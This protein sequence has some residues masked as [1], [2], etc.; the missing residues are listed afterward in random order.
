MKEMGQFELLG[1][2]T[3]VEAITKVYNEIAMKTEQLV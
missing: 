3:E 1:I 2:D